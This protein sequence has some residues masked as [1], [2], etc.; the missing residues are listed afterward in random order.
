MGDKAAGCRTEWV[1]LLREALSVVPPRNVQR[2]VS[3]RVPSVTVCGGGKVV[4]RRQS[5][6]TRLRGTRPIGAVR[7][8]LVT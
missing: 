5:T 3:V 1:A 6:T 8:L 4:V 7:I 2:T